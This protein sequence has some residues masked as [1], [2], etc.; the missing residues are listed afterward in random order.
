MGLKG[1][2][3]LRGSSSVCTRAATV[4]A[5]VGFAVLDLAEVAVDPVP[6]TPAG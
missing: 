3:E 5:A 4:Q 6:M 1:G 2:V